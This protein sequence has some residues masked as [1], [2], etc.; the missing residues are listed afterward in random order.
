M[1]AEC[2]KVRIGVWIKGFGNIGQRTDAHVKAGLFKK[3][4][5]HCVVASF[6][7]LLFSARNVPH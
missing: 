4:A 2:R 1:K 7:L 5:P 3:F 6:A